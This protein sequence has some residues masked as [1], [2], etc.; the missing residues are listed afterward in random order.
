MSLKS[1]KA[2]FTFTFRHL[3]RLLIFIVI[4]YLLLTYFSSRNQSLSSLPFNLSLPSS[5]EITTSLYQ[6]LPLKSRQQLENINEL[7][8]ILFVQDKIDL[9]KE[10]SRDFPQKQIKDFQKWL[11]TNVA[12]ELLNKIEKN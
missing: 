8:P 9:F 7:P 3:V 12:N 2:K 6:R 5:S 11:I 4:Y 10:Q 1:K